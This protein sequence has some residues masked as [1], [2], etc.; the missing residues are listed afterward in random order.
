MRALARCADVRCGFHSDLVVS[1]VADGVAR[2]IVPSHRCAF[3]S[4]MLAVTFAAEPT[5]EPELVAS[6]D[7]ETPS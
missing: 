4:T 6:L 2:A 3:G 7:D 1:R 5:T